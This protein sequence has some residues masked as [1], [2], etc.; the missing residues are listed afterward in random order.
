MGRFALPTGPWLKTPEACAA[1]GISRDTLRARMHAG[2]LEAGTHWIATGTSEKA[3][4][5]W[6]IEACMAAMQQW[7]APQPPSRGKG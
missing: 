4:K 5:L 2:L 7:S 1:L 6:N 3:P